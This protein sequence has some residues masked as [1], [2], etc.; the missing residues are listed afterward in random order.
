MRRPATSRLAWVCRRWC[1]PGAVQR[2]ATR[3]GAP[4]TR[5]IPGDNTYSNYQEANR[6]P[7]LGLV[8]RVLPLA[9]MC[10]ADCQ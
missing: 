7:A 6:T 8:S 1:I 10:E 4:Q 9:L 5:D 3:N 2:G